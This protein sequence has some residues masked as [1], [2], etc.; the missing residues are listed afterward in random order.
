[1]L[2]RRQCDLVLAGAVNAADDLFLHV[3]G[4]QAL[5]PTGQSRPFAQADGLLPAEGAGMVALKRLS[6]PCGMSPFWCDSRRWAG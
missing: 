3:A 1:M 4:A 2:N 5:S 6:D